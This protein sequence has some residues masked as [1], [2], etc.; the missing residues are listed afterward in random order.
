M[1]KESDLETMFFRLLI[2]LKILCSLIL[3]AMKKI[4]LSICLF[5]F[6][7]WSFCTETHRRRLDG[8]AE[9][10]STILDNCVACEL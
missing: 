3:I 2:S 6:V 1:I 5:F 7:G 9:P 8:Q 10:R 4:I